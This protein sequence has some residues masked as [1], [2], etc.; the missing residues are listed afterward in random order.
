[1]E[2]SGKE[3]GCVSERKELLNMLREMW[4]EGELPL[5]RIYPSLEELEANVDITVE[6]KRK[7]I[8][9][10]IKTCP[11]CGSKQK[12]RRPPENLFPY[13][14]CKSCGQPFHV[15]SDLTVR[16]LTAEEQENMPA[17]WVRIL[18]DLDK[19]KLAI[20]FKLE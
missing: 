1:L 17:D 14:N 18:E 2:T 4:Q 16:K 3:G 9:S 10:A 5:R 13:H 19:K 15:S 12:I 20:V 11:N 6:G 7:N 8:K